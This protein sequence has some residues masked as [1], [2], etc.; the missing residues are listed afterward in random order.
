MQ[1]FTSS[2]FRIILN[3]TL[4]RA[5]PNPSR[6]YWDFDHSVDMDDEFA[7]AFK[8]LET[9]YIHE[10]KIPPGWTQPVTKEEEM[11]A[12]LKSQNASAILM[13]DCWYFDDPEI[14]AMFKIRYG[15]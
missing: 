9:E 15:I 14:A 1:H 4:K 13:L 6:E 5:F 10:V 2:N 3:E 8:K 12:W 7:E 11:V